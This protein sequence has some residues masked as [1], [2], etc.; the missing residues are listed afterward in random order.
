MKLNKLEQIIAAS[1][2]VIFLAPIAIGSVVPKYES[3]PASESVESSEFTAEDERTIEFTAQF[4]ANKTTPGELAAL[5]LACNADDTTGMD[6]LGVRVFNRTC[7]LLQ[8][9]KGDLN[10]N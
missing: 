10:V 1:A 4:A 6:R 7:E 3:S 2:A 5:L 9:K 8:T